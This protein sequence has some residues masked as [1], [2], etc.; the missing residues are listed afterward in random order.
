MVDCAAAVEDALQS[1]SRTRAEVVEHGYLMDTGDRAKRC[2]RFGSGSLAFEVLA[3]VGFERNGG[4]AP[5]LRTVVHQAVFADIKESATGAAIP[6]VR[7]AAADVLLKMI[8][9]GKREH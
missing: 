3:G 4:S 2:A 5:L 1:F 8:E 7:Q 9:V 6:L